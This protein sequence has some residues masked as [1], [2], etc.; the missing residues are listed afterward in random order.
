[1][2]R[3]LVVGLIV[4]AGSALAGCGGSEKVVS[5]H[6]ALATFRKAGFR[7][8]IVLSNRKAAEQLGLAGAA[9]AADMDTIVASVNGRPELLYGPLLAVRLHSVGVA[10]DDYAKFWTPKAIRA[11]LKVARA[12]HVVPLGFDLRRFRSL[13]V[14]NLLVQSYNAHGDPGLSARFN[15][16]VRLL[17]NE[18]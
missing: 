7:S 8:L 1:M 13:R 10:K 4:V 2:R 5:T 6:T 15:R 18:C 3:L 16:A 9:K 14:C 12:Q 11:A 17:R